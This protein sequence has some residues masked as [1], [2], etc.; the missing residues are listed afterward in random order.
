M[1]AATQFRFSARAAFLTYPQCD[2]PAQALHDFLSDIAPT[3]YIHVAKENHAD[4]QP[5]LH[6][7]VCFTKKFS[8]RNQAI[9]DCQGKHPNIQSA[10]NT[11]AV[12]DYLEKSPIDTVKSG[13]APHNKVT[14][15]HVLSAETEDKALELAAKASPRDF[16]LQNDKIRAFA[17]TKKR[18]TNPYQSGDYQFLLEPRMT[19]WLNTEFTKPVGLL[20]LWFYNDDH[21]LIF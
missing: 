8:S 18:R 3:T 10:R 6:A 21:G 19:D 7:L 11:K 13:S 16:I 15:Q 14:W 17:A 2:I 5:H 1:P 9:F 20:P 4:G 12:D